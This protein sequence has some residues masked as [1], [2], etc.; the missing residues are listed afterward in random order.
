MEIE[1]K[2]LIRSLP[3]NLLE[4]QALRI[5]QAY[6]CTDPVVRVRRQNDEYILT[7]KSKGFL[8]REEYNLPLTEESYLHL[9]KKAD[10][11]ILSKTRYVIPLS[12]DLKIEL[13]MFDF[14]YETLRLAEVEFPTEEAAAAFTPPDWFG[15]DVTHSP[16][17]QNSTLS[18]F[19]AT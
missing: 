17:Y 4:Y 1:R 13:D 9:R 5:E 10:G 6:L 18:L 16:R 19:D 3:E 7:Y 2:F 15:E 8:S 11:I 14:P 12:D